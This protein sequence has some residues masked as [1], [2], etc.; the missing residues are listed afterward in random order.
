MFI[1][2]NGGFIM[3]SQERKSIICRHL[4]GKSN[5]EIYLLTYKA[6]ATHQLNEYRDKE[7][8]R[9][10]RFM[11]AKMYGLDPNE[12]FLTK[13]EVMNRETERKRRHEA[14]SVITKWAESLNDGLGFIPDIDGK[15]P[16]EGGRPICRVCGE[17]HSPDELYLL[18]KH[19]INWLEQPE[20]TEGS[21][22]PEIMLYKKALCEKH[23]E[24]L[25]KLIIETAQKNG[26]YIGR[27]ERGREYHTLGDIIRPR[28][29][30]E[31]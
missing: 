4:Q 1:N 20:L 29:R 19:V 27:W 24:E 21:S 10:C 26:I 25:H 23:F 7:F 3:N 31:R 15:P 5:D 12:D 6:I 30:F 22:R 18:D 2:Y 16:D 28:R 17:P 8:C 13:R 14:F 11:L 9:V